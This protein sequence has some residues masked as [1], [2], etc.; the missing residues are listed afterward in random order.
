[1]TNR[2]FEAAGVDDLVR[3]IHTA[4][5]A[6]SQRKEPTMRDRLIDRLGSCERFTGVGPIVT[7]ADAYADRMTDEQYEQMKAQAQVHS[8]V[9]QQGRALLDRLITRKEDH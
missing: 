6:R 2:K 3:A 5:L 7:M 8:I 4:D 9:E 1:M